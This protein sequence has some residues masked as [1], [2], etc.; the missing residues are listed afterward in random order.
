MVAMGVRGRW[1]KDGDFGSECG[2][3]QPHPTSA[4]VTRGHGRGSDAEEQRRCCRKQREGVHEGMKEDDDGEHAPEV[5]CCLGKCELQCSGCRISWR[6][7]VG[8]RRCERTCRR[9]QGQAKIS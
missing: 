6:R 3:R 8:G 5:S 7:D 1:G 9:H 4:R 2:R